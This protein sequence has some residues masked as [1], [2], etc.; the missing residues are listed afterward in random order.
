[1]TVIRKRD[2]IRGVRNRWRK[3]YQ[4]QIADRTDPLHNNSARVDDALFRLDVE[5]CSES[6]V[7]AAIGVAGWVANRCDFCDRD[8]DALIQL[9]QEP[10]YEARYV[11]ICSACLSKA[12]DSLNV[13]R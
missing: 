9:G 8:M 13:A 7:D 3:Q 1:M 12:S 2:L 4:R 6:D 5:A 10:D 11:D